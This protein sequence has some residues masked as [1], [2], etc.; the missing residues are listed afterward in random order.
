MSACRNKKWG[1]Y[2]WLQ[3]RSSSQSQLNQSKNKVSWCKSLGVWCLKTY[4]Q[5]SGLWRDPCLQICCLQHR[6]ACFI[7]SGPLHSTPVAVLGSCPTVL[8]SPECCRLSCNWASPSPRASELFQGLLPCCMVANLNFSQW[9]L[10]LSVFYCNWGCTFTSRLSLCHG[11][12]ILHD[13]IH[14]SKIS[15]TWKTPT[16][17]QVQLPIQITALGTSGPCVLTLWKYLS[18]DFTSMMRVSS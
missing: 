5:S 7:D 3:E 6:T 13:P 18:E 8:T 4:S 14:A 2:F 9:P 1:K 17:C 12:T 11:S 15:N 10:Q 16:A